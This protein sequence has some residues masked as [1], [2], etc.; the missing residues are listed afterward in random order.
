MC[1]PSDGELVRQSKQGGCEAFSHLVTR[2]YSR[3]VNL[4]FRIVRDRDDAKDIAQAVFV[5]AYE[6]LDTFD[7]KFEFTSWIYKIAVNES[8][9]LL[10]K[11]KNQEGLNDNELVADTS[12]EDSYRRSELTSR[13]EEAMME[14]EAPARALIVLRHFADLSY[15]ELSYIFDTPAK[16]IK[17]RLH[18][19]RR[20]LSKSLVRRGIEASE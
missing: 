13:V 9:N 11:R 19:A 12:P 7:P 17:S 20:T 15:R 4:A 10:R 1:E 6:K 18:Y 14:L 8:I 2:Y 16:T 5:K 3:I